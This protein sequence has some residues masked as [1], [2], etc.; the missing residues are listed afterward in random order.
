MK[1][2]IKTS[3]TLYNDVDWVTIIDLNNNNVANF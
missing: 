3:V 1:V 2:E